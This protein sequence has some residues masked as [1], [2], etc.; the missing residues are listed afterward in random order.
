[1]R[2]HLAIAASLACFVSLVAVA[3]AITRDERQGIRA[4]VH[5]LADPKLACSRLTQNYLA[6][7]YGADGPKGRKRCRRSARNEAKRNPNVGVKRMRIVKASDK[8]AR[9]RVV[10]TDGDR[11]VLILVL[12]PR[13]WLVDAIK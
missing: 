12:S 9:V 11:V 6:Y 3:T 13:G 5:K 1:M 2:A 7:A 10:D 4:A 8:R